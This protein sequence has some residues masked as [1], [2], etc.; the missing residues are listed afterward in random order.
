MQRLKLSVSIVLP[1]YNER[2]NILILIPKIEK[3]FQENKTFLLEEIII[4]DDYSNDGTTTVC[5]KLNRKYQNIIVLQ[6]E[7]EGIGA[8]LQYGYN[9]TKGDIIL[10]MDSDLSFSVED[11]LRLLGKIGEGYDFVLG[12]RHIKG[13]NYE[14]RRM[15]TKIK[16]VI[17]RLGNTFTTVLLRINVHD[18]SGNFR[19][20]R[21][22]VWKQINVT[23][24]TNL[25]LLEMIVKAQRTNISMTEVPVIFQ[26]RKYGKS[27][28]KL[29][30]ESFRFLYGLLFCRWR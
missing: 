15:T 13:G 5:H 23:E 11:I 1:T 30:R 3:L 6:K 7:K 4:V 12:S 19:A 29:W 27:K 8:A 21:K 28:L 17:S 24:K 9:H 2:E 14:K 22:T 18:F 25:M 20:I 26:E 10:S 16:G